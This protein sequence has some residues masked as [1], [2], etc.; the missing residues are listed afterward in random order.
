MSSSSDSEDDLYTNTGSIFGK[1]TQKASESVPEIETK[2]LNEDVDDLPLNKRKSYEDDVSLNKR[3]SDVLDEDDI[4]ILEETVTPKRSKGKKKTEV[5]TIESPASQNAS[6]NDSV[7][8]IEKINA[9]L[10]RNK[11]GRG[12][13]KSRGTPRGKKSV[14]SPRNMNVDPSPRILRSRGRGR[15]RSKRTSRRIVM[16]DIGPQVVATIELDVD[17]PIL[18]SNDFVNNVDLGEETTVKV[19]WKNQAYKKFEFRKKE[20]LDKIFKYYAQKANVSE[21]LLYFSYND[22]VVCKTDTPESLNLNI[23]SIIEGGILSTK[24]HLSSGYKQDTLELKIQ[25]KNLKKPFIYN[26]KVTDE[27]CVL[28]QECSN[29]MN[30]A[31]NKL[32]FYFDGEIIEPDDTPSS[33]DLEGGE[34]I[35]CVER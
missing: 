20:K 22:T 24:T 29:Q 2:V 30:V 16:P 34:C 26:M 8:V 17:Y 11:R 18:N 12:R 1:I 7:D 13:R 14:V 32:K 4:L 3:K 23:A 31:L 25:W 19:L 33:L 21:E 6:L 10:E 27:M 5:I 15:G 35:D 9:C 28:M